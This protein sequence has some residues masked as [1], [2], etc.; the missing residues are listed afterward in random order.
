[1]IGGGPVGAC[2]AMCAVTAGAAR[3]V[4]VD[5]DDSR[6]DWAGSQGWLAAQPDSPAS[7]DADVVIEAVG[8]AEALRC[9]VRAAARCGRVVAIGAHHSPDLPFPA[10]IA[11]ARELS[12][13]FV[14]G[15]PIRF[16]D[17]VLDLI[18]ADRLNPMVLVSHR[19]PL[20]AAANGYRLF[21][22]REAVKVLLHV[23]DW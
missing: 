14:V 8:D 21:D 7:R 5:R 23:G 3:V 10:D 18:R 2:A 1:V 4:V 11:F 12:V 19:F 9:A 6:R 17:R 22:R 16:R 15:D 20:S 13:R